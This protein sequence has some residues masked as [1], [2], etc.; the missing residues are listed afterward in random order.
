M[1]PTLAQSLVVT[2]FLTHTI[3]HKTII[4]SFDIENSRSMNLISD[5]NDNLA[6]SIDSFKQE[7]FNNHENSVKI[8]KPKDNSIVSSLITFT[9][10]LQTRTPSTSE[11]NND[12]VVI[13][14]EN[15]TEL[16]TLL[17][18]VNSFLENINNIFTK[19]RIYIFISSTIIKNMGQGIILSNETIGFPVDS[20]VF[21]VFS[22]AETLTI[23]VWEKL[24][25]KKK[26]LTP[27]EPIYSWNPKN[28]SDFE[29]LKC[30]QKI[31]LIQKTFIP[32]TISHRRQNLEW[33]NIAA[34]AQVCKILINEC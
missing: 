21:L 29:G 15:F 33:I 10:F 8:S 19:P 3:Q 13:C 30:I 7:S 28:Y 12:I 18:K 23:S 31:S 22:D 11:F 24:R 6:A 32:S 26:T 1:S 14:P 9:D 34:V 25:Y 4:T 20:E 27:A 5:F 17:D 16:F 2:V